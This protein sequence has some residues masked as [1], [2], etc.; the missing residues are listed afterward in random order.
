MLTPQDAR[1]VF[2]KSVSFFTESPETIPKSKLVFKFFHDYESKFGELS[3]IRRLE[4]RMADLFPEDPQLV[5]FTERFATERFNPIT[6]R[7]NISPATQSRPKLPPG[8]LHSIEGTQPSPKPLP[9]QLINSPKR[10]LPSDESDS[11]QP[12]KFA[13]GESPLKGAAGRRQQ[14]QKRNQQRLDNIAENSG[15]YQPAAP[16]LPQQIMGLLNIL[17]SARHYDSVV[18]PPEKVVDMLRRVD[19]S[20]AKI[21]KGPRQMMGHTP[22]PMPPQMPPQMPPHMAPQMQHQ[23]SSQA[24][25]HM[26]PPMGY[27]Q[28]NCK[29]SS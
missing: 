23:L 29:Y 2:E 3:Q 13:R 27:G 26:Q 22:Q 5:L 10:P 14:Q 21:D 17:P 9:A 24:T 16:P 11:E 28:P 19:M 8:I 20:K 6:Y 18:F 4:K 12:R 1:A 15:R 7:T 25:P